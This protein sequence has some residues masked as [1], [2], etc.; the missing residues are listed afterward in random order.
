MIRDA[1]LVP[2]LVEK[3]VVLLGWIGHDPRLKKETLT[4]GEHPSE[5]LREGQD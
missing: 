5:Q 3:R 1:G 4:T 2:S